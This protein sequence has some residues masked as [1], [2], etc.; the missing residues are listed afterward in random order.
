MALVKAGEGFELV[1]ATGLMPKLRIKTFQ[2]REIPWGGGRR[3]D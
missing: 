1:G 2:L 3:Y